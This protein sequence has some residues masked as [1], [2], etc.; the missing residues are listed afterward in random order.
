MATEVTND[1]VQ[2][3]KDSLKK[4]GFEHALQRCSVDCVKAGM[5]ADAFTYQVVALFATYILASS[6][7]SHSDLEAKFEVLQQNSRSMVML[8]QQV[9]LQLAKQLDAQ[10]E[11][12]QAVLDK[13]KAH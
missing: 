11:A 4:H 12:E 1:T 6:M 2:F 7:Q 13:V 3:V 5:D 9:T 10:R 8:V